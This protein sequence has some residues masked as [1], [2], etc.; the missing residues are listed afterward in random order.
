MV[1]QVTVNR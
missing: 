1:T